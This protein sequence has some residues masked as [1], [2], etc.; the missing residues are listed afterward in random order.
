MVLITSGAVISAKERYYTWK[1]KKSMRSNKCPHP[2]S[3]GFRIYDVSLDT[4]LKPIRK[5]YESYCKPNQITL[6]STAVTL[7]KLFSTKVIL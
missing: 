7:Q 1:R 5:N 2:I 4:L 6:P 3:L